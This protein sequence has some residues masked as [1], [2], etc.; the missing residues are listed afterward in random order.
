VTTFDI[1]EVRKIIL[2][3][4]SSFPSN[5]SWRFFPASTTFA[6]PSQPFAGG[7][8]AESISISDLQADNLNASFKGVKS[9]DVNNS[10]TPGQ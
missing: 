9:G 2:G 1:S 10:A 5:T 3:I 7:L 8:P 4:N 6:N